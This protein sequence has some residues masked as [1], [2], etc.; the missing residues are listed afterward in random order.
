M[1]V[2]KLSNI[3]GIGSIKTTYPNMLTN[4]GDFGAMTRIN[5]AAG[6][7]TF[8]A[9]IFSNIPQTFQDLLFVVYG[10]GTNASAT[11]QG[12]LRLND[13]SSSNYSSTSLIGDGSSATSSRETNLT[14]G[15]TINNFTGASATSGLFGATLIHI[16]NYKSSTFKTFIWRNVNDMNGSGTT[17]LVTGLWRSTSAIND[18]RL[19]HAQANWAAGSTFALY[20]IKASA[21]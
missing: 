10:R 20:G 13:D 5:Y 21:A 18:I 3:G 1:A 12:Y 14:N 19:I 9:P 6:D 2:K 17:R 7:G 8:N 15:F 4:Y 11:S 16:I